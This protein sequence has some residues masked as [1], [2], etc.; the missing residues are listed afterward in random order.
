M[1]DTEL[2]TA[3]ASNCQKIDDRLSLMEEIL[4][5]AIV[6]PGKWMPYIVIG[7]VVLVFILC[8]TF[9][10]CFWTIRPL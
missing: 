5:G 8:F 2:L 7:G 4:S 9:A 1:D 10:F 6:I 3:L